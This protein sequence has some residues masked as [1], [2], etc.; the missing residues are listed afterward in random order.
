MQRCSMAVELRVA[1]LTITSPDPGALAHFYADL[2]GGDVVV[3]EL[4]DNEEDRPQVRWA[5]VRFGGE[6][7][8][9]FLNVEFER[10]WQRPVW[11][12]EQG[13]QFPS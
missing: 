9:F 12:A 3:E 11:P 4:A 7:H 6:S 13:E 5:Q 10:A 2:L 1:S 8:P